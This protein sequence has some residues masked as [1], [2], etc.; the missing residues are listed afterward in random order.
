MVES[1]GLPWD[2]ISCIVLEIIAVEVPPPSAVVV[3]MSV[4][5]VVEL[6]IEVVVG[7]SA[8]VV[9]LM[10]IWVTVVVEVVLVFV[11]VEVELAVAVVVGVVSV[12]V[13]VLEELGVKVVVTEVVCAIFV[14]SMS[15]VDTVALLAKI[16]HKDFFEKDVEMS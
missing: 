13:V 8:L 12:S 3:L 10:E 16:D 15:S 9:A 2:V 4:V 7:V 14:V 6:G 5:E 1:E 11:V